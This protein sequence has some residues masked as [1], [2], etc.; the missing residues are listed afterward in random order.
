MISFFLSC[1]LKKENVFVNKFSEFQGTEVPKTHL[2]VG[3]RHRD[4]DVS[5][6]EDSSRMK[7]GPK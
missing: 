4:S 3:D 5:R 1:P 6:V 7:R 2:N